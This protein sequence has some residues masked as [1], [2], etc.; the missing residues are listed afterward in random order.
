V[1][2]E[3]GLVLVTSTTGS[4]KSTTLPAMIAAGPSTAV[5]ASTA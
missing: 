3:R 1:L 4:G 2:E 5:R